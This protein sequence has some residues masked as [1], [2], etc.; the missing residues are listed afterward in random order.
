MQIKNS[1]YV[2]TYFKY[3]VP[4]K[5]NIRVQ[6]GSNHFYV[7]CGLENIFLMPSPQKNYLTVRVF[8]YHSQKLLRY[9]NCSLWLILQNQPLFRMH[10]PSSVPA[11]SHCAI[12][13]HCSFI[14]SI[15][16]GTLPSPY[17]CRNCPWINSFPW[18]ISRHWRRVSSYNAF[19]K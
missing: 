6:S 2:K 9:S 1:K 3:S 11:S 17:A 16:C 7:S 10:Q 18:K 12:F 14:W 13:L 8:R 4:Q 15:G 5:G 19:Q